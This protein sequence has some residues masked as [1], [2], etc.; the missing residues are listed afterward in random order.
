MFIEKSVQ[1]V[2]PEGVHDIVYSEFPGD[3]EKTVICVHG[4]SRNGRD[5][6]WLAQALSISGFRVICPDMAGRGRSKKFNNPAFYNYPQYAS[7][8][9]ILM[10]HLGVTS[11]DWIGTS[12]G[13]LLG[14]MIGAQPNTP[15]KRLVIN[16]IG[17][18]IPA[19]ALERI[20]KYVAINPTYHDWE[21]FHAAF[22]KRMVPFGL[23]E[24]AEWDYFARISAQEDLMGGYSMNYDPRIVAGMSEGPIVDLNLWPLWAMV[25][26]PVL[27]LHGADSDVLST[28]TLHQM[29]IDKKAT[30]VS[31]SGV[32]HAPALLS[33]DQISV[34]KNWLNS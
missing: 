33:A 32:G 24:S 25:K 2:H 3:P 27:I 11:V 10:Q 31:F 19:E 22:V 17:P 21:S 29:M 4:L 20:K 14:M 30:S 1:C 8:L 34:V 5:F 9:N 28:D 13:G 26:Q 7:D 6:D 23:K 12:M 18:Y 15:I 16:D